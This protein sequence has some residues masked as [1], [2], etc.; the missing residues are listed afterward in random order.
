MLRKGSEEIRA[1][2]KRMEE[3]KKCLKFKDELFT[4]QFIAFQA[5]IQNHLH[6]RHVKFSEGETKN[7]DKF[8]KRFVENHYNP[9]NRYA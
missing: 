5:S 9:H 4:E 7:F 1:I 8:I 6:I 2:E 3:K